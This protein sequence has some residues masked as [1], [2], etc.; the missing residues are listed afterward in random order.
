LQPLYRSMIRSFISSEDPDFA[1][2]G[3]SIAKGNVDM[4]A[5]SRK[6]ALHTLLMIVILEKYV[7]KNVH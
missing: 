7:C 1:N 3:S 2:G 4:A 5:L 6:K